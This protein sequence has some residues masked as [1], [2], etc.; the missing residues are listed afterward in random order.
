MCV[1]VGGA[2]GEEGDSK[3]ISVR[4]N[5]QIEWSLIML[6]EGISINRINI[7]GEMHFKGDLKK[8]KETIVLIIRVKSFH[9]EWLIVSE[10]WWEGVLKK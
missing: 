1:C 4:W 10:A 8:D 3:L 6:E 7:F 5:K 2:G 9:Q